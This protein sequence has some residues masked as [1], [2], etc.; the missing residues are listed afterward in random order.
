M[1]YLSLAALVVLAAG[2]AMAQDCDTAGINALIDQ[3]AQTEAAGDMRAQARLMADDRVWVA[4]A[5]GRMT[6]QGMNMAG[7]QA[8]FDF[9]NG[10]LSGITRFVDA[11]DRLIRCYGSGDVAVASFYWYQQMVPPATMTPAQAQMLG[12]PPQPS[13]VSLVL[14]NRGGNWRIVHT[15]TSPLWPPGGGDDD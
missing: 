5:Q 6:D 14:E 11:R 1:K 13:T 10:V 15:H 12:E 4:A 8:W 2:P 3:Y 7:Q 9:D